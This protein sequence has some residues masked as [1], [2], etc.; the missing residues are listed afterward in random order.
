MSNNQT[1][2]LGTIELASDAVGINEVMVLASVGIQRKTPVAISSLNAELITE[3]IG[4]QEFPEI[5]QTTP[6]VYATKEGGGY[7][8]GRLN[9]RGFDSPNVAV[10]I[11]GIPVNDMEWGGIYWSNWMGM[12]DV[13]PKFTSTTRTGSFES[14]SSF[15]WWIS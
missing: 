2:D 7:G 15:C 14:C 10:M 5:L 12:T 13:T 9:L 6:G 8:D 4:T 3:K 1:K 11:N